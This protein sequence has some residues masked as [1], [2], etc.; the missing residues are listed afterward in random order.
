M[1]IGVDGSHDEHVAHER[2]DNKQAGVEIDC[3]M[4]EELHTRPLA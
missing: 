1:T 4:A 3:I 2:R